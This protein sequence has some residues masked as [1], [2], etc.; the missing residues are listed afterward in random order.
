MSE[1]QK[2]ADNRSRFTTDEF[3]AFVKSGWAPRASGLP[4]RSP[5]AA[6]AARRREMVSAAY[7][8]ERLIVPAGG[9]KVRSNDTDYVFR[10]HSAFAHLTGLGADREPDAV[11][12]LE[13]RTGE[14]GSPDGHDSILF[15]KPLADRDSDEFFDDSRYGEFWVGARPSLADIELELG[16]T[17]RHVD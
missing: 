9:L 8:G 15:L 3:R 12:L 6:F 4:E 13:P 2:K 14:D 17:A 16:L 11:L 10:P 5:A 1:E 7:P